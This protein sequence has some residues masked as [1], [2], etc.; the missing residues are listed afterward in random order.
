MRV[1]QPTQRE[2]KVPSLAQPH[3]AAPGKQSTGT[4]ARSGSKTA[5]AILLPAHDSLKAQ[6]TILQ[7]VS[8]TYKATA[9]GEATV[10]GLIKRAE[11]L[12]CSNLI[13]PHIICPL[14]THSSP[15]TVAL[16]IMIPLIQITI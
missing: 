6:K 16:S 7:H 11:Y 13:T 15:H 9:T 4:P 14:Q 5:L 12:P 1:K 10:L 3:R 8:S 2:A